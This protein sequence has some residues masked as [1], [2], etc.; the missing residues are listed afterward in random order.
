MGHPTSLIG[1]NM[2]KEEVDN[3]ATLFK[4]QGGSQEIFLGAAIWEIK[5]Y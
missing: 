5:S 2:D 4:Y 3:W 1:I